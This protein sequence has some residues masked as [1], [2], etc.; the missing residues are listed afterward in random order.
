MDIITQLG[1]TPDGRVLVAMS[2]TLFAQLQALGGT[3]NT[4]PPVANLKPLRD[5]YVTSNQAKDEAATLQ[6]ALVE[7]LAAMGVE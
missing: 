4:S 2:A 1:S 6:A 7:W 3:T 5:L